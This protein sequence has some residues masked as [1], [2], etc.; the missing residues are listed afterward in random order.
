MWEPYVNLDLEKLLGSLGVEVVRSAYISDWINENILYNPSRLF[1]KMRFKRAAKPY[2]SCFVGGHGWESV[3]DTILFAEKK[4]DGIIHILPFTCTPEIVA[5]SILTNVSRDY[6]IPILTLSLDEHSGQ[7]G[8]LTR[9][10]AFIDMVRE[11]KRA[12]V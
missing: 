4:F 9:V 5:Q 6:K 7:A 1:R 3:G 8:F 2:L 10:E 12:I 11:R